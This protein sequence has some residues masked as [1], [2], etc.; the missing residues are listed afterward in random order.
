MLGLNSDDSVKRLKG[1]GRPVMSHTDRALMLA[2]HEAIDYVVIFDED[3]PEKL[4]AHVR[5]MIVV[6]GGDYTPETVVGREIVE[7]YGGRVEIVPILE[8][9]STSSIVDKIKKMD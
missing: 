7:G 1:E 4:I 3:T 9:Y 8:G 5:P 2:S 6:K